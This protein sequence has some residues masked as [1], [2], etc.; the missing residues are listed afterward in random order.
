M[1][2]FDS[3]TPF[4]EGRWK[5]AKAGDRASDSCPIPVVRMSRLP[6]RDSAGLSPASPLS[7]AIRG[8]GHLHGKLIQLL[9]RPTCLRFAQ[10]ICLELQQG[11][12]TVRV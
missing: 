1:C 5:T 12:L 3:P 9:E 8:V 11:T 10:D 2:A 4:R 7:P 6:L